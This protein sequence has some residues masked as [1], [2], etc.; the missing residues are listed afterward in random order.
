MGTDHSAAPQT[1]VVRPAL[2]GDRLHGS[3][4]GGL[5]ATLYLGKI[6]TAIFLLLIVS[7]EAA[8]WTTIDRNRSKR[9]EWGGPCRSPDRVRRTSRALGVHSLSMV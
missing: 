7:F 5:P 8:G 6:E 3:H 2:H 1:A 4:P 9:P